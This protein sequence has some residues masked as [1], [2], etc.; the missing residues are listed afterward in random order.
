MLSTN[1][2]TNYF[3]E[4][5]R[6]LGFTNQNDAKAFFGAKD[7]LPQV[8]LDYVEQLNLRLAEIVNKIN[9]I[10]P[11]HIRHNR[12]D[13][14]NKEFITDA[15]KIMKDFNILARLNNQ[16]RRPEEVY[17]SWMRGYII[18]NYFMKALSVMF[19]TE[20]EE[21]EVVGDDDLKNI[22]TFK[23]TPTADLQVHLNGF[24]KVRLEIQSGF[25]GVNDIKQ[26]KVLEAKRIFQEDDIITLVVHFDIYDGQ[27]AIVRV[28][29]ISD[30]DVNW[31]TRQQMEG[32]TV[33]NIDQNYFVWKLTED[34]PNT[35]DI[36][37]IISRNG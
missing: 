11:V 14:F 34:C 21:I 23:R 13:E 1:I 30:A 9:S 2:D 24:G 18:A 29:D 8:D 28:D 6:N 31:I 17:F 12:T 25:Q 27:V 37:G 35:E 3:R 22:A 7:V 16:G 33:F 5:R 20:L 10:V 15:F 36:A 19:G 26:H 4:F 32:Q